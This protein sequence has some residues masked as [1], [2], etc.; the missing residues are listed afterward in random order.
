M[1]NLNLEQNF[2]PIIIDKDVQCKALSKSDFIR[3]NNYLIDFN[4]DLKHL[5]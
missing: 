2:A 4:A 5:V 1:N 3:L